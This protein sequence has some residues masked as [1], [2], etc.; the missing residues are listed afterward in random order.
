MFHCGHW[1]FD[2]YFYMQKY[3]IFLSSTVILSYVNVCV[4]FFSLTVYLKHFP[5]DGEAVGSTT[6]WDSEG[7]GG[8]T[9][10]QRLVVKAVQAEGW[11]RG[12]PSK[13]ASSPE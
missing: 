8:V 2:K 11:I 12:F 3:S 10:L 13:Q 6:W 9:K 7:G 1:D 4:Y 5:S